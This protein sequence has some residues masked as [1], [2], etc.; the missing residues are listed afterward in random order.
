MNRKPK[1]ESGDAEM[2][3]ISKQL[4]KYVDKIMKAAQNP[5]IRGLPKN[6]PGGIVVQA[7]LPGGIGIRKA[8]KGGMRGKK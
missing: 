8:K 2:N 1:Q 5:N 6:I 4:E 7:N 3:E